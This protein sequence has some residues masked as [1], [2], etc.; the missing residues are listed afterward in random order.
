MELKTS[1]EFEAKLKAVGKK[2]QAALNKVKLSDLIELD[3]PPKDRYSLEYFDNLEYEDNNT[4][5][6]QPNG[7]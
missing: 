2:L 4:K 6:E 5:E 3:R 7:K 1:P